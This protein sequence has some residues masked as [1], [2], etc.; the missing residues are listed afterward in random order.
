MGMRWIDE[1]SCRAGW[2]LIL[3]TDN[4]RHWQRNVVSPP[5][6]A[7]GD[8]L[9]FNW[10]IIAVGNKAMLG[11]GATQE[12][13]RCVLQ[14]Q[15]KGNKT[16]A[17]RH[18]CYCS[19]PREISCLFVPTRERQA[20]SFEPVVELRHRVGTVLRME[21]S[22]SEGIGIGKILRS[23]CHACNWMVRRESPDRSAEV[24]QFLLSGA[25]PEQAAVILHHVNAGTPIGGI[26][27]HMHRSI[28]N[29]YTAQRPQS[30]IRIG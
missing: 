4:P 22:I 9:A 7:K 11:Y 2:H 29:K 26:D 13:D 30:D 14:R 3:N 8:W 21:Q 10:A 28:G 24:Q 16:F 15:R 19:A 20:A 27:H 18:R 5:I 23:S 25:D 12:L 17:V 1:D 6:T